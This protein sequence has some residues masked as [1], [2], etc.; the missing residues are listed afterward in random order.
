MESIPLGERAFLGV[1]R[2]G[3]LLFTDNGSGASARL[4]A[5][6][7]DGRLV[8]GEVTITAPRVTGRI[9]NQIPFGRIEEIIND[10]GRAEVIRSDLGAER[11]D[12]PT[13][14]DLAVAPTRRALAPIAVPEGRSYSDEFYA[15]VARSY[16]AHAAQSRR[17]AAD[18]A[19]LQGVPSS[20]VHRW[21]KEARRRGVMAPS[22]R[23][24]SKEVER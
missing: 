14:A 21:I 23:S 7:R 6:D 11:T 22:S 19:A 4:D 5:I 20:T 1:G 17:P 16:A 8:I 2:G 9:V 18:M 3:V 10:P 12:E 13:V 15:D 24:A